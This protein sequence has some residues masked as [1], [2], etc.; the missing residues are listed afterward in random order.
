[1]SVGRI[2]DHKRKQQEE[3]ERKTKEFLEKGGNIE[4]VEIE[5]Q[6]VYRPVTFHLQGPHDN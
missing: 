6:R 1:M 4:V 3:I 2:D 5:K